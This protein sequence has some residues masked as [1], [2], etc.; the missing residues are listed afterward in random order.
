VFAVFVQRA[1]TELAAAGH[2]SERTGPRQR[3]PLFDASALR[4]F[5]AEPTQQVFL[6][7]LLVTG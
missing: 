2:V 5:L 3:V 6:A 4:E 1:A 7:E